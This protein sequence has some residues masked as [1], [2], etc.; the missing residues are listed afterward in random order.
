ME[1]LEWNVF[2]DDFNTSEIKI[3]NIFN[4]Y[5]F[6][7]DLIDINKKHNEDFINFAEEVK[8]SLMYHYRCKCEWE[9]VV[10]SF[11]PYINEKEFL[12]LNLERDERIMK[13]GRFIRESVNL[14]TSEKVDVYKQVMMNRNQF[15]NYLWDN[16][17][18][19]KKCK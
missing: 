18:L 7:L 8:S 14:E 10:T 12:R 2:I 17:K 15:I 19:I 6:M 11:P 3:H 9:V 4:H 5:G 13:Y 1:R 16:R